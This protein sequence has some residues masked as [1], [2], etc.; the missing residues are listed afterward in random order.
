MLGGFTCP[1]C[2]TVNVCSCQSCAPYIKEG[3]CVSEWIEDGGYLIC[4]KCKQVYSPNAA[5]D[6]ECK[7]TKPSEY[8][9]NW[10]RGKSGK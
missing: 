10:I 4:G 2:G 6:V 3:D 9:Y 5:L 7:K 8:M 1:G